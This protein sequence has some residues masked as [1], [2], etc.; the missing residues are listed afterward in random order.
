MPDR[1]DEPE[2]DDGNLWS[3]TPCNDR[4]Q[5][6]H[7]SKL[8]CVPHGSCLAPLSTPPQRVHV[9]PHLRA[10]S[11]FTALLSGTSILPLQNPLVPRAHIALF[12]TLLHMHMPT[13]LSHTII[14]ESSLSTASL[15]RLPH[16]LH[17]QEMQCHSHTWQ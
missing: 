8:K 11:L 17:A 7:P 10:S 9:F 5:T 1:H 4:S 6:A 15:H 12:P 16:A 2:H 13:V 14:C 3:A